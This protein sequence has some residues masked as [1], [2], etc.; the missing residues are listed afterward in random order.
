MKSGSDNLKCHDDRHMSSEVTHKFRQ[1]YALLDRLYE[2]ISESYIL[3]CRSN[4]DRP[5]KG[6]AYKDALFL[7]DQAV[8]NMEECKVVIGREVS[9]RRARP[10]GDTKLMNELRSAQVLIGTEEV[11]GMFRS[12]GF[13]F[14]N[15]RTF[16]A[17][18]FKWDFCPSRSRHPLAFGRDDV[19]RW[20]N[21]KHNQHLLYQWERLHADYV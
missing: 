2:D 3:G 19:R 15:Y 8:R 1:C 7:L 5:M 9:R 17:N 14:V 11:L 16:I 18:R 13:E 10:G 12:A 4:N 6:N 21:N 20:L